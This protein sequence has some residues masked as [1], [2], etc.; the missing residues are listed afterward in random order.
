[1][2]KTILYSVIAL[3]LSL[4]VVGVTPLVFAPTDPNEDQEPSQ[5]EKIA[6]RLGHIADILN[7][8][9]ARLD[10]ISAAVGAGPINDPPTIQTLLD[11][12]SSA[13]SISASANSMLNCGPNGCPP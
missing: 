5:D 11:I 6:K 8:A 3:V 2:N 13:N 7:R 4:T 1:M 9:Q 10:K 12:I